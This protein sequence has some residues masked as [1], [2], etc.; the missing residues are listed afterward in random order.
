[1]QSVA[2]YTTDE[3]MVVKIFR[4]INAFPVTINRKK[5]C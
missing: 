2:I 1:M 5:I 4:K 3:I